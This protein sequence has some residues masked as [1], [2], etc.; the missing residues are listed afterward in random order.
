MAKVETANPCVARDVF[1]KGTRAAAAA[2]A[3]AAAAA[4]ASWC[5][6]PAEEGYVPESDGHAVETEDEP[7]CGGVPELLMW[8]HEGE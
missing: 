4:A 5:R 6:V 1:G 7:A 8:Q 3:T 2:A